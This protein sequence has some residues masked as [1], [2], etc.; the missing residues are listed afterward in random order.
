MGTRNLSRVRF[1]LIASLTLP[2]LGWAGDDPPKSPA[3]PAN[4]LAR[5]TSP[6]LLLHAHNPVDWY[7]WGPEAFARAK[8][9]NKPIFLSVGYSSCYWCH[10]MERESFV[11][12]EIAKALNANFVCIKVDREERPDVDQVY[13][14]A[15]QAFG[16]GGW[17]MS[18]F[19]M[20][21][22]RP[23]FAGTYFPPRD[24]EGVSG[25]LTIVSAVAKAWDKQRDAIEKTAVAA[26]DAVRRRLK[27]AGGARKLELSKDWAAAGLK[28]LAEQFDPEYGGFGYRPDN[29]RRPKFPQEAD[30]AFLL[31]QHQRQAAGK[32][33]EK[34]EVPQLPL[35]PAVD[36]PLRNGD[37]KTAAADPL[38]MVLLTLDR[39]ARG[40]IRD[41]L[42]GGYH[43]YA[44]DRFWTVPHFEKML[45]DN[46]QLASLHL[47]AYELTRNP[48]WRDEAE[49]TFVFIESKMTAP[50]GGFFSA[51]DAE[52]NGEEGAY[53][54]WTRDQV[55]AALGEGRDTDVFCEAYGLNLEPNFEQGRHVLHEPRTRADLAR[56]LKTT[57]AELEA[58]LAPLRARLLAVRQKRPAPLC[59]DKILTGWNGLMIAAYADGYRILKHKKY[60][61]A[62][63]K[64]A[65]FVL[66]TLRLPDGRLLRTYRQGKAKLP[67]YLEDYA[68]LVYGLLKLH[69]ATDDPRWLREATGLTDRMLADF[70]DTDEGGFYFTSDSHETLLAR[71]KDPFDSA[72]PSGNS[73]A[74]IDLIALSRSTGNPG[75]RDHAG[76]ALAAFSTVL[77]ETPAA[78]PLGLVGL[79]QY[80]DSAPDR[81]TPK[82][83]AGETLPE[84]PPSVVAASLR[85]TGD[86]AAAIAPSKEFDATM[87]VTIQQGW[88]LYANPAGLPELNPTTLQL[89]S[90]AGKTV[91]LVKVSYPE[92]KAQV[93]EPG[94]PD[95]VYVYEGK[96]ELKVRLR[97]ADEAEPGSVSVP[98]VLSYQACNDR[99]CLAPAKLR[100]ALIVTGK[101]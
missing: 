49:T 57:P 21:D 20:P 64:A 18:L 73:M 14:A 33:S 7:P 36:S 43:R 3:R 9:E 67:A 93:V 6:Y 39:M 88:H 63:E 84:T 40:G 77:A 62:A 42:G 38:R 51:F 85:L 28:Q 79:G 87:T 15:L 1:A 54:V 53:Y 26:T 50:E 22:G 19:L 47:L 45:Y 2:C 97:L 12:A 95:K 72:L 13:M 29:P 37:A 24:R 27:A 69:A 94:G 30:L 59:D 16:P 11:D 78:M 46:A 100:V 48:R 5:E 82:P 58:A 31:D 75:Y 10:V 60:R 25:F 101:R 92:G 65:G 44:T 86:S 32:G 34:P 71:A 80:F 41:H 96:V 98:L 68:F 8:A 83:L 23:F 74:I 89:D 91:S 56:A 66:S 99:L 55:R 52:T 81:I 61:E 17:P 35:A 76:K 4:R 90:A 70:E